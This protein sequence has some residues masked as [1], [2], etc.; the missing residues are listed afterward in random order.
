[1]ASGVQMATKKRTK[2]KNNRISPRF[3]KEQME[4]IGSLCK[5]GYGKDPTSVVKTIV[6]IWLHENGLLKGGNRK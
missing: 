5:T 6:I 4:R 2:S 1:M 3:S